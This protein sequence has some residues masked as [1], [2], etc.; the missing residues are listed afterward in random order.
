MRP[1]SD[2]RLR[3]R[4]VAVAIAI[5]GILVVAANPAT[6]GAAPGDATVVPLQITGPPSERLNLVVMGDGY[7]AARDTE[8]PRRRRPEPER[9]VERRAVPQ[10]PQLFQRVPARDRV[11][12]T[13]ASG[14]TPTTATSGATRRC[15]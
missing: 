11:A 7:T 13:R 8:V 6:A 5:A 14:A 4:A 10:L 2:A 12:R 3:R 1:T 9:P 15:A